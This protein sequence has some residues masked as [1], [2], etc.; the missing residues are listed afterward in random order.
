MILF[1]YILGEYFR[2]VLATLFLVAFLFVLLDVVHNSGGYFAKYNAQTDEIARYYFYRLPFQIIQAV[3]IGAML[4]SVVVMVLLERS[5]E[6]A[7]MRA[8]GLGPLDIARPLAVGGL[9]LTLFA[10]VVG[11]KIIPK[12]SQL[13]HY[14]KEVEIE[15]ES[16]LGGNEQRNWLRSGNQL[17]HYKEYQPQNYTLQGLELVTL[18]E[19]FLPSLAYHSEWAVYKPESQLWRLQDT[20]LL[21]FD[22]LGQL[23]SQESIAEIHLPLPIDPKK[24][25]IDRRR[26]DELSLSELSERVISGRNIGED[27]LQFQVAWHAKLAFPLAAI[28]ISFLG[29]PLAFRSDRG[30]NPITS[31]LLA[32][33]I[34]LSY[35]VVFS[36]CRALGNAGTLPPFLAGWSA[37]FVLLA[38]VSAQFWRHMRPQH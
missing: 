13:A 25:K 12:S 15:G 28:L 33:T 8:S 26:P 6:I 35:W 37:N 10:F 31:I 21:R 19:N 16:A 38:L 3:P 5:N 22:S 18:G 1:R 32:F 27:V 17:V 24:L 11:E 34:G 2:Y 20:D 4:A 9:S 29:L 36:A 30:S 7:A 14:I 23:I